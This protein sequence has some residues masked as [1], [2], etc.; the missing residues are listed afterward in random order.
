MRR[1][2]DHD[3]V[4]GASES[5]LLAVRM[6]A[7]AYKRVKVG[8]RDWLPTCRIDC[9]QVL[10]GGPARGLHRRRGVKGRLH[11]ARAVR[12]RARRVLGAAAIIGGA[13]ALCLVA[14]LGLTHSGN[15]SA[16]SY[17]K[18]AN[19]SSHATTGRHESRTDTVG[20]SQ[21]PHSSGVGGMPA[22]STA[23]IPDQPSIPDLP[24]DLPIPSLPSDLP[25]PS[26]PSDLPISN[27]PSIPNLPS[28]LDG[29]S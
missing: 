5:E 1:I 23:S 29:T 9:Q 17:H 26:L 24:S 18:P 15:G 6:L 19:H 22:P 28:S 16:A 10:H 21:P 8:E 2:A 25:I 3:A 12:V 14:A 20:N 11:V 13:T 7:E 4:P 27:L